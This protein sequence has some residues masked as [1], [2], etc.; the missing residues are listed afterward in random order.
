MS[1]DTQEDNSIKFEPVAKPCFPK[2]T[3]ILFFTGNTLTLF[4]LLR[5]ANST[6]TEEIIA[7]MSMILQTMRK[8]NN[9]NQFQEETYVKL[10]SN[11]DETQS[12]T[13]NGP[14]PGIPVDDE[15]L[16]REELKYSVKIFLRSLDAD[17]LRQTIDSILNELKETFIESVMISLPNYGSHI[18]LEEFLPLWNVVEDF[19]DRKK[20]LSAGV[21]DFML[22]LLSDL[23][24]SAKH[25][26]YANQINLGVCCSIP[27][28]LNTYVKNNNIQLLTHSDPIDVLTDSDFQETVREYCHE[29]DS[30]NWK[31]LSIVRYSSVITNRGIIKTKGFLVYAKRDLRMP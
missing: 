29:Y 1:S 9:E 8:E 21:C 30:F 25:K 11:S 31:P 4:P 17:V 18:T 26:P 13:V 5:K 19:I 14:A 15:Q 24:D 28:E 27:E 12:T 20:I 6:I 22:P 16:T 3:E 7:Y 23:N 10:L 2:A